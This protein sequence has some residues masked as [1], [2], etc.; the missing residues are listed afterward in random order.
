M[1]R[2]RQRA[3]DGKELTTVVEVIEAEPNEMRPCDMSLSVGAMQWFGITDSTISKV[4]TGLNSIEIVRN[5]SCQW[6]FNY[7]NYGD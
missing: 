1:P 5:P 2:T 4:T 7:V 6:E 3:S